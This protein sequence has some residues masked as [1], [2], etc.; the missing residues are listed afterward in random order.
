MNGDDGSSHVDAIRRALSEAGITGPNLDRLADLDDITVDDV[1]ALSAIAKDRATQNPTGLLVKMIDGGQRSATS[2][3]TYADE[4]PRATKPSR[5]ED[6][7][8]IFADYAAH[9]GT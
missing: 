6:V 8:A 2:Q 3:Q 1:E 5:P 4:R 9:A 7:Q